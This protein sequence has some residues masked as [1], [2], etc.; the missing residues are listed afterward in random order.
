MKNFLLVIL[1]IATVSLGV[2]CANQRSQIAKIQSHLA[3][4]QNQLQ[5]KSEADEKVAF[6]ERKAKVL[7]NILTETSHYANKQSEQVTQLQQSLAGAKTNGAFGGLAAMLKDPKMRDMIKAQQQ[8]IIGPLIAK[9]YAAF[10]QQ[11]DLPPDKA[12][13]LKDLIQKKMSVGTDTGMSMLDESL[14]AS[15]RADLAKQIKSQTDDYDDQIKEL[16]GADDYQN[17][18]AYQKTIPARTTVNQFG[19]QLAGTPTA[20]SADQQQQLIQ[21]MS[22][23]RNNFKWTTDFN[24]ANNAAN[25]G[26]ASMFTDDKINQFADENAQLDQQITA[27]AK[28]ILTPEQLTSFEQFQ[29]AQRQMQTVGMK[30]AV[31]MFGQKNH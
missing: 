29:T 24:N 10:L 27:Q 23:T 26:Y 18:Q 5:E 3:D 12:A 8:A 14:D 9:Q 13:A 31:Q 6:A 21:A 4:T 2:F 1:A 7:Q 20:L 17:F 30:M 22:D 28:Q 15:Q 25:G 16:L 19:D 11:V